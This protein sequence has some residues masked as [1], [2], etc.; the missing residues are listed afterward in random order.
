MTQQTTLEVQGMGCGSCIG[1][2][3]QA[4]LALAGV[5]EVEV[6]L[7]EGHVVIRHDPQAVS[8]SRLAAA[9]GEAGFESRVGGATRPT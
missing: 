4:L 9:L 1:H 5:D 8:S 7:H 3:R 6:R 2:V